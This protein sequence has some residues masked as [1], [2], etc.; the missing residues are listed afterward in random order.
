V[1][2][3]A[4][5]SNVT[6]APKCDQASLMALL[7]QKGP[8]GVRMNPYCDSFMSYSSGIID[9]DCRADCTVRGCSLSIQ[10]CVPESR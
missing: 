5:L 3:Y 6:T 4:T 2:T 1:P 8:I 9:D 10:L 7:D